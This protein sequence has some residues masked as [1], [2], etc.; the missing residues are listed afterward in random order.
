MSTGRFKAGDSTQWATPTYSD[1][2]WQGDVS[3]DSPIRKNESL[4]QTG[5]GWYRL[6]I[7]VPKVRR[8]K[9]LD[10]VVEQFG[11]SDI[12]LDG[13][14]LA[15]LTPSRIDSG[16]SQRVVQLVPLPITDTNRHLLA[17]RYR[18]RKDPVVFAE[19]SQQP[20]KL[21]VAQASESLTNYHLSDVFG[22]GIEFLAAG[23]CSTLSLLHFL[24][25][26]TNRKQRINRTLC[27]AMLAL[28]ATFIADELDGFTPNLTL[29]SLAEL[30]SSAGIR[31]ACI[32]FLY[33]VYQYLNIPVGVYF[34]AILALLTGD[35]LYRA[36]IGTLPGYTNTA[37]FLLAFAD[38]IRLSWLGRKRKDRDSRLPWNS[39]KTALLCFV[40]II[41]SIVVWVLLSKWLH[42]EVLNELIMYPV[43]VLM[44]GTAL[45]IPV[46]LSLSL[47]RDYA[48]T[49]KSLNGKLAEVEQLSARTVAQEQEK[50]ALLARQNETLEQLVQQRTAALDQSL[51][52]LRTTQD[53]LI[54]RE[55]L[56]S[57]GELTAGVAHEIQNPLNFVNNF[58]DV[59]VDLLTE[60][61]EEQIRPAAERDLEL[62]V[63]LLTDIKPNIGKISHHG[64][65]AA[66][67]VRGMLQH[68]R[69][70]TGQREPTDL[71]ALTDEY[72][73]LAYHGLRA[74]NK[75][76]EVSLVTQFDADLPPV[77]VVPPG[78]GR[79]LMNLFSNA[80]H[81][82][83]ARTEN[84][85]GPYLPTVTVCTEWAGT[86]VQIRVRDNGTG[87][88]DEVRDKIFQPFFTTKP[89][90]KGTGLGLSLSYDIVTKGHGGTISVQSTPGE[91][92]EFVVSL[93][94]P[95]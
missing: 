54:Q 17:I 40:G 2:H 47:V 56:A 10:L 90:G 70:S 22:S 62:E 48:N 92:S 1:R 64:K 93:P 83:Q 53:Q 28:A 23:L 95:L 88:A 80:F 85:T 78:I 45:S 5:K 3:P 11:R 67:I 59:S 81:A 8:D 21:T 31:A 71:N 7:Q 9:P 16:G 75:S 46:G 68:S 69:A 82:V 52:E 86:T 6:L 84:K 74:S 55:K 30:V 60:L 89:T 63:E 39:L 72:L 38:Y 18:F 19:W 24:F 58:S 65:R 42:I 25:F 27:W 33:G 51:T 79:V 37:G 35:L 29:D 76:F 36:T 50:Q 49:L 94:I 44:I 34:Y 32:L 41:V 14:L 66:S 57:L 43:L 77:P 87:V 26:R 91:F 20:M 4:W 61:E 13:R 73:R 15:T 12:Y